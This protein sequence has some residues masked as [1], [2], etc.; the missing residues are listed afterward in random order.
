MSEPIIPDPIDSDALS[1]LQPEPTT[2]FG[3]PDHNASKDKSRLLSFGRPGNG[4]RAGKAKKEE[5]A[6]L[7]SFN[8]KRRGQF[9]KPLA[10]MYTMVGMTVLTFDMTC[11][12]TIIENAE[13]CAKTLDDL[14][15][16]NDAVRRVLISLVT[17]SI[18]GAVIVAHAPI[19]FAIMVHHAPFMRDKMSDSMIKGVEEML[20]DAADKDLEDDE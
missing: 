15:Y 2:E 8:P 20:K 7:A 11:G 14:A 16:K 18:W 17:T 5:S 13:R 9:V 4:V 19:I 1:S 12:Q 6:F 10:D 3:V